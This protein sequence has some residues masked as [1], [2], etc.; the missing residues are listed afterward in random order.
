MRL[1]KKI[2]MYIFIAINLLMI[3]AMNFCAYTSYLHPQSHP[4]LAYFGLMFPVFLVATA[5]FVPFWLIFKWKLTALPL[6]GMLLC[7][8]SVRTYV[9]VNIPVTPPEGCLKF[10][11][12]NVMSF[13][14][15]RKSPWEENP[16]LHYMLESGAD[17]ICMQEG[18]KDFID[19]ALDTIAR[20]YP[21]Y[22]LELTPNNYIACFSK[23]PIDSV[24]KFDYP[25]KSNASYV[26]EMLVDED[27][28][29]VINNHFESYRLSK[30][31][32]AD[33]K[34]IFENYK[35]PD[36]NDS[37]LKYLTLTDKLAH[38]DSLRG[39][40]T[41]SVAAFVERNRGRYIIA[42][43]DFNSSPI[44]Y[45]HRRMTEELNDAYTRTGNGPGLSYN[46]SGMYFRLDNILVSPNITAYGAKVDR[47][48][49]TSDHYP[50]YCFVKL[51]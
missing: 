18:R 20:I 6:V 33:Y 16:I 25:S 21:Y 10:L 27:T 47:S 13:G 19:K 28:V 44:S 32:K 46:R 9:P 37:D 35:H 17:I 30:E 5:C 26:Y 41:D 15:D 2:P 51:E 38:C 50:I 40:Q 1:L 23:F 8:G 36:Q 29:L 12:Y 45:T 14:D 24:M 43:G 7:A 4:H 34:S 48:I 31:D 42:C 39:I 22:S 49:K 3:V 11:S